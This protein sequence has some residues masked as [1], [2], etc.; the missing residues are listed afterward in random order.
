MGRCHEVGPARKRPMKVI[1]NA[2]S[3]RS[4]RP[5]Q[6][7]LVAQF[8]IQVRGRERVRPFCAKQSQFKRPGWP[9]LRIADS[10]LGMQ[11][12]KRRAIRGQEMSNK[13]NSRA[14]SAGSPGHS[15]PNKANSARSVPVRA[16]SEPAEEALG[17]NALR[18][19]YERGQWR[20]TKPILA[21]EASALIM[22]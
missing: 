4:N 6:R 22:D 13:P 8:V 21:E 3:R 14:L 15:A 9:R 2:H 20:Q 12:R 16:C 17:E 5:V 10:G 18:R 1:P 11:S 7:D 19:H